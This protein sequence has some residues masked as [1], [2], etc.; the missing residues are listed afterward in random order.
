[1]CQWARP[2]PRPFPSSRRRSRI[3]P[4]SWIAHAAHHEPEK[5]S[6]LGQGGAD[7]SAGRSRPPIANAVNR[8]VADIPTARRRRRRRSGPVPGRS[9]RGCGRCRRASGRRTPGRHTSPR[10]CRDAL[11][12]SPRPSGTGRGRTA[13]TR[14]ARSSTDQSGSEPGD[15]T[16]SLAPPRTRRPSCKACSTGTTRPRPLR[17]RRPRPRTP[18]P[19][20]TLLRPLPPAR[21]CTTPVVAGSPRTRPPRPG[22]ARSHR[23]R[24]TSQT[25]HP[26]RS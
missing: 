8:T 16:D 25:A 20:Y 1:M 24:R 19:T 4:A 12:D 7:G 9:P 18:R 2:D 17:C 10:P 26:C 21:G 3:T 23:T 11:P 5:Q 15:G 6:P 22:G 13:S 14:R